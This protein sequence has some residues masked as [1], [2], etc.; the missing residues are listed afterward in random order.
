MIIMSFDLPKDRVPKGNNNQKR[1]FHGAANIVEVP[2][3][4]SDTTGKSTLINRKNTQQ[5]HKHT[6]ETIT[7][8][9]D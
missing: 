4:P 5:Q 3:Q 1:S 7:L 2:T 9:T 6:Q 8:L